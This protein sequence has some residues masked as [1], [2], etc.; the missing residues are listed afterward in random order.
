MLAAVASLWLLDV[1][2]VWAFVAACLWVALARAGSVATLMAVGLFLLAL[3]R[4]WNYGRALARLE[5]DPALASY[6]PIG[7]A[8]LGA[9]LLSSLRAHRATGNIEW[10]GRHYS[11]K[12]K[13]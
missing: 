12:G 7:A 13:E 3:A 5:F 1:F 8:L 9:L 6:Q 2:P 10:K 4:Q 11:T